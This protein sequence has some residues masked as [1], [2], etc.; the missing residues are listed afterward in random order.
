MSSGKDMGKDM[1][2]FFVEI[3]NVFLC[4]V[5]KYMMAFERKAERF[6]KC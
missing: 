2:V 3:C 6:Q 5:Y 1:H 4:R